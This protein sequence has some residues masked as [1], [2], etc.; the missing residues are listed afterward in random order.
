M[1]EQRVAQILEGIAEDKVPATL[2]L[3]PAIR[4]QVQPR[5]RPSRWARIVPATANLTA[6]SKDRTTLRKRLLAGKPFPAHRRATWTAKVATASALLLLVV[7]A[8]FAASPPLRTWA[9]EVLA[10]VGNMIITD[11]PTDAEQMLPGLLTATPEWVEGPSPESLSQEEASR[12]VGFAVL[13]PRD[14]PKGEDIYAPLWGA[15]WE[16]KWDIYAVRNEVVVAGIYN[17][18]YSVR[19]SQLKLT[20]EQS[21]DLAIGD[22]DIVA[23]TVRGQTGYWI[24][25]AT[26]SMTLLSVVGSLKVPDPD[27][28]LANENILTWEEEGIVFVIYGDDELSQ[29]EI[30]TI[31]ESL[32]P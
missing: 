29:D 25:E 22:A 10:R 12:R 18:W 31:A 21:K 8:A 19:I 23:V 7:V 13:V 9:Q 14:I 2:D 11:A 27:W 6:L 1:K 20:D 4:A 24:E 5:R 32:A 16:D 17:R 26:T 28:Q 30:L 15:P 3:W